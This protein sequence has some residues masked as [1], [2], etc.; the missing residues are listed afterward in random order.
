MLRIRGTIGD[1]PVDLT[2]ELEEGDW[3]RLGRLGAGPRRSG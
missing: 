1:Q 3:Q 2:V